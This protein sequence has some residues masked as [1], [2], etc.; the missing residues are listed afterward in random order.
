RPVQR[1][2]RVQ[3]RRVRCHERADD[4]GG[5][6]RQG[7]QA[8]RRDLREIPDY[9]GLSRAPPPV[10]W[11]RSQTPLSEHRTIGRLSQ[12][13]DRWICTC[14]CFALDFRR[15]GCRR[16]VP[17]FRAEHTVSTRPTHRLSIGTIRL[18]WAND[19]YLRDPSV[20]LVPPSGRN[21][22]FFL[23]AAAYGEGL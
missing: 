14:L 10:S 4:T 7:V 9:A 20:P 6:D 22:R 19:R 18:A 1:R 12:V 15:G 11:R 3:H 23:L 13:C 17:T 8:G 5:G 2:P 16:Q 21:R